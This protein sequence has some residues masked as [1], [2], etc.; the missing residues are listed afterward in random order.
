[1]KSVLLSLSFICSMLFSMVSCQSQ[2]TRS[3]PTHEEISNKIIFRNDARIEQ[4][5]SRMLQ[6]AAK[7][8]GAKF[9]QAQFN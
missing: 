9:V 7:T 2:G 6:T 5:L 3:L 4:E 1:M 8:Q